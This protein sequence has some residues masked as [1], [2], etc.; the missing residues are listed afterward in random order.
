MQNSQYATI[1]IDNNIA[2]I[3]RNYRLSP[4]QL[5]Y[6]TIVVYS[7]IGVYSDVKLPKRVIIREVRRALNH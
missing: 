4:D 2:V 3:N 6:T 5:L 1:I 7:D